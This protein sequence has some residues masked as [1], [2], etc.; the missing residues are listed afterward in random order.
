MTDVTRSWPLYLFTVTKLRHSIFSFS[1]QKMD[2]AGCF[3]TLV[4]LYLI[5]YHILQERNFHAAVRTP[6]DL[7]M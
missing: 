6:G 5:T 7:R 3:E 2:A 1:S 4:N